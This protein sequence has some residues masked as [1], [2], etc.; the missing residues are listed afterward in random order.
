[1][2]CRRSLRPVGRAPNPHFAFG[3]GKHTC[4]GN[5]LGRMEGRIAIGEFTRRFPKLRQ[6]GEPSLMGRA[7][8]RGF[9]RYPVRVD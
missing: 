7:R 5:T 4:L 9:N 3:D 2:L 1:M 6:N 8:F